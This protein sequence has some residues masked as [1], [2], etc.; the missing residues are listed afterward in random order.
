LPNPECQAGPLVAM[1]S[2]YRC[3]D[4]VGHL[5]PNN[6]LDSAGV[7]VITRGWPVP[8][9]TADCRVCCDPD[10][11]GNGI[12]EPGDKQVSSTGLECA[13][14]VGLCSGGAGNERGLYCGCTTDDQCA[15]QPANIG[16]GLADGRPD[17]CCYSRPQL[18]SIDPAPAAVPPRDIPCGNPAFRY[19]FDRK[20]DPNSFILDS[21]VIVRVNGIAV[22][23]TD[24]TIRTFAN[25]F[26]Y[27]HGTIFGVMDNV[28]IELIEQDI[29]S[30]KGVAMVQVGGVDNPAQYS[31]IDNVICQIDHLSVLRRLN[32]GT[33]IKQPFL[34][35]CSVDGCSLDD[36]ATDPGNQMEIEAVPRDANGWLLGGGFDFTWNEASGDP[37][38]IFDV[39]HDGAG[40]VP[41]P[42]N[43]T[44]S[45]DCMLTSNDIKDCGSLRLTADGTGIPGYDM[46]SVTQ[47]VRICAPLCLLAWPD[48]R[49]PISDA[50][51]FEDSENDPN[52]CVSYGNY[53]S[54]QKCD[55]SPFDTAGNNNYIMNFSTWYCG[56][57]QNLPPLA[58]TAEVIVTETDPAEVLPN[59]G[60]DSKLKQYFFVYPGVCD[61]GASPTASMC[62]GAGGTWTS[63]SSDAIGIQVYE[64]EG[65]LSPDQWYKK[66]WPGGP[67]S[68]RITVDGYPAVRSGRTVYVAAMNIIGGNIYNNIYLITYHPDSSAETISIYNALLDNLKFN[69]NIDPKRQMT[70]FQCLKGVLILAT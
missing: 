4:P 16:C 40:N 70:D 5:D 36:M 34:Y 39:T 27:S 60:V 9:A 57:S 25:G 59:D 17:H 41:C 43:Q 24:G 19:T 21:S 51:V 3:V 15:V 22:P 31:I 18:A 29:L 64:N 10:M 46:G 35:H 65:G 26:T 55:N 7:P 20:M 66:H 52:G 61:D 33:T 56:D 48:S 30:A 53:D 11:N 14:D 54:T 47:G 62:D 50:F 67:A 6:I 63:V 13:P 68:Q 23:D 37:S 32:V 8:P 2:D 38:N 42:A 12:I 1:P 45:W 44:D 49:A 58:T 28:E 69:V